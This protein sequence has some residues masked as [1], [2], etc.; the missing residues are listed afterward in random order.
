MYLDKEPVDLAMQYPDI[1]STLTPQQQELLCM[2]AYM[3]EPYDNSAKKFATQLLGIKNVELDVEVHCLVEKALLVAENDYYWKR[4]KSYRVAPVYHLRMLCWMY[5]FHPEWE[6][7]FRKVPGGEYKDLLAIVKALRAGNVDKLKLQCDDYIDDELNDIL[8]WTY[9]EP[10]L[11]PLFRNM[12]DEVLEDI[13]DSIME[14]Q[15][16]NPVGFHLF[17]D[18]LADG[19]KKH[20]MELLQGYFD[21]CRIND[22]IC[23]GTY[24]ENPKGETTERGFMLR[25]MHEAYARRIPEALANMEKALKLHNKNATGYYDEKNIFNG[26][27]TNFYMMLIYALDGT[28][29]SKRKLE[30][31]CKKKHI[32]E[33]HNGEPA[34][35]L[36]TYFKD[37]NMNILKDPITKCLCDKEGYYVEPDVRNLAY[38]LMQYFELTPQQLT[39][40]RYYKQPDLS[41]EKYIPVKA[42]LRHELSPYIPISEEE[43]AELTKRFGGEP[44]LASIYRKREWELVFDELLELSQQDQQKIPTAKTEYRLLY[45]IKKSMEY[46]EVREQKRLKNGQWSAGKLLTPN[47]YTQGNF[48]ME[49]V[50]RD[51]WQ[52][53]KALYHM[54]TV[55]MAV[56][57][58]VGSDRV[59]LQKTTSDS[60]YYAHY[61]N[62]DA[63]VREEKPF[64]TVERQGK[65]IV[66]KTNL[67]SLA[68]LDKQYSYYIDWNNNIITYYPFT[69]RERMFFRKLLSLKNIPIEAEETLK[70]L[71]PAICKEV[72]VNCDF[73]EGGT[74]LEE[75][76]GSSLAI[77]RVQPRPNNIFQLSIFIRPLAD[78]KQVFPPG[79][80]QNPAFGELHGKRVQVK[81][82]LRH[83]QENARVF[84]DFLEEMDVELRRDMADLSIEQLLELMEFTQNHAEHGVLEWPEQQKMKMLVA[85][86]QTWKVSLTKKSGWF[87]LEGEIALDEDTVMNI[88][89]LLELLSQSDGRYIRLEG[90][91]YLSISEQLRKQLRRIEAVSSRQHGKTVIPAVG[92]AV[93]GDALSGELEIAHPKS[94]DDLRSKIR[95]S[96][97]LNP[98]VPGQL[99]ATL[100]DYQVDGYQWMTRLGAWGAGACLADDMGLGKTV[101]T[102]A[103][104]LDR[105]SQGASL[106]V[107]PASVVPNW[108]KEIR[109]FA[110]SLTVRILNE[111]ADRKQL[112]ES[113][114]AGH[115]VVSTY[116]LLVTEEELLTGRKWNVICLDEAHSIK[117][118]DT[119]TSASAMKLEAEQRIILTGTPI[120]N[121]LGE[122]WNL[123][124]FINPGL[125]GS[126][127]QFQKKYILPV[128]QDHDTQRQ[129]QL[130]RVVAPF[131]LR[132]TK[133]EV[134]EE[135]P[136]KTEIIHTV[137]LSTE[138]MAI[139]EVYRRKAKRELEDLEAAGK[140]LNVNVLSEI[141]RLRQCACAVSLADKTFA[142]TTF[143][144][145]DAFA[146]LAFDIYQAGHHTLVFSQFTSFLEM[147]A[148]RLDTL[149][150]PY[151]YLD[152][153]TTMRKR[154]QMVEA[155]QKGERPIFLVSLKA[156][157]LG[158]NLTGANYVIH[159]DPWWNPAIE[160]QATDRA[161]RIGQRQ[162]VTVYHLISAHTIEE[163]ILRLHEAKRDLATSILE[164]T[165]TSHKITAA[166][167]LQMIEEGD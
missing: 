24:V 161:Y 79:L 97:R 136:D 18:S 140:A 43:K 95:K 30:I 164:G 100:R 77:L 32:S 26:Y 122:L 19:R 134:V 106:V 60:L 46:V 53:S 145:L 63:E 6:K 119:K 71:L 52:R 120:Q 162:N 101:Q 150:I 40:N 25:A 57:H 90:D 62:Y 86:P 10:E 156:G 143:A 121:H 94:L 44:L 124:Q 132:R 3:E 105:A 69:D 107:A 51:L 151:F 29:A 39:F 139:Y 126:Y 99:N 47:A 15:E 155:F 116:G 54:P 11:L 123:F 78:D 85:N 35:V 21:F 16:N 33:S 1:L 110:P 142:G 73:I 113:V 50:D 157:G 9:A 88:A 82:S 128:S 37:S 137:E 165:D 127:E 158:L 58:L 93:M 12:D 135:L 64:L 167:L 38:L 166:Q 20:R 23:F 152:G 149:N 59:Q 148:K 163:K 129:Q 109:R 138:E 91:K 55:G 7:E 45:S 118:R 8:A 14:T 130:K 103:V 4:E 70:K 125:L 13:L 83:E 65:K 17:L 68:L 154:T 74:Q 133:Q 22:F 48:Q 42:L 81:R 131:M 102:I 112:I 34:Y 92:M 2:I 108:S 36:G 153:S 67:P 117:N 84:R 147:A 144:K 80:G 141:T 160:Q 96:A 56:S 111:S 114:E 41:P 49:D 27:V 5:E 89:Q 98:E 72:D 87:D 159:L 61:E 76:E 31:A 28:M 66:M 146:Q 115:V 104:L 75:V